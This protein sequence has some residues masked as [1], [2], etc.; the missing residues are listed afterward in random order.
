MIAD[1]AP[2]R[3]QI[4]APELARHLARGADE[5]ADR[6]QASERR[7][8]EEE[9]GK[10]DATGKLGHDRADHTGEAR[11]PQGERSPT[12]QEHHGRAPAESP[13]PGRQQ[14]AEPRNGV[15]AVRGIAERQ[16][17]REGE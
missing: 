9:P 10:P 4:A 16:I 14:S 2:G 5:A 11:D 1:R 7:R 8:L 17:D 6:E 12:D 13:L 15:V 3:R